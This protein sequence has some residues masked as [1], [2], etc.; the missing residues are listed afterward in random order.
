MTDKTL[1]VHAGGS[2]TG[3]SALQNFFEINAPRLESLGFAYE[4]KLDIKHRYEINSGNGELLYEVLWSAK[5]TNNEIDSL[6]L[7]YF[8]RCN[9]AICSSENFQELCAD[10]WKK[11]FESSMRLGVKLKVIFYV[12]NVIPF[13]QS[14]YNQLIKRAGEYRSFDEWF[15][16]EKWPWQHARALRKIANE[17][18]QSSVQVLHFDSEKA[19]LIRGF[20]DILGVDASLEVDPNDQRRIVNPSLTEPQREALKNVNRFLGKAYSEELSN[21]LI[22]ANPNSREEP[23]SCHKTTIDSSLDR[24]SNEVDWVNNTFFNGQAIVSV[25]STEPIKKTLSK[26]SIIQSTHNSAIEKQLFDWA[27]EK[28]KTIKDETEQRL[29]NALINA[30][31]IDSGKF[32]PEIPADFDPL[33]Y[34]LINTDVLHTGYDPIKHFIC[35]GNKEGRAYKFFKETELI[36]TDCEFYGNPLENIVSRIGYV[37]RL[38]DEKYRNEFDALSEEMQLIALKLAKLDLASPDVIAHLYQNLTNYELQL[39]DN[40]QIRYFTKDFSLE[41]NGQRIGFKDLE[42]ALQTLKKIDLVGGTHNLQTFLE[43]VSQRMGWPS[44]QHIPKENFNNEKYGMDI[45]NPAMVNALWPFI[46][47]DYALYSQRANFLCSTNTT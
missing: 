8:G 27:L 15:V 40:C 3:S 33:T 16:E 5:T 7:S 26:K 4:H 13:L 19:N 2:K 44:P 30:A 17:L 9:N 29:L 43:A 42:Y 39:F 14:A 45:R 24:F 34:L 20:L 21:L 46:H 32:H 12:R 47:F 35:H 28:L 31:Q 41:P 11:L 38:A 37:S 22:Y 1:F 18:P 6:V 10:H 23:V 36:M 25:L